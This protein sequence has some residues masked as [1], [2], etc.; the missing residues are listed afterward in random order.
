MFNITVI[1]HG[2][3][4]TSE[5]DAHHPHSIEEIR[6]MARA[7]KEPSM[8]LYMSWDILNTDTGEVLVSWDS[9]TEE[10]FVAPAIAGF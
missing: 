1:I 10:E 9:D 7:F 2:L 3:F 6:K 8:F 5:D 4:R